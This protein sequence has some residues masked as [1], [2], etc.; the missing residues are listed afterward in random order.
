MIRDSRSDDARA[1]IG[2]RFANRLRPEYLRLMLAL[3]VLGRGQVVST[4][5][6]TDAYGASAEHLAIHV[7]LDGT[8][9]TESSRRCGP[10][11]RRPVAWLPGWSP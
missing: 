8:G 4:D 10:W 3:L 2:T 9:S 6:A 11:R 7:E 5:A 1:Q